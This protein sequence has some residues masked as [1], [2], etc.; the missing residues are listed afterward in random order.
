MIRFLIVTMALMLSCLGVEAQ[1]TPAQK[2]KRM[3]WWKDARFGMF[4]HWGTYSV[5]EG[6]WNGQDRYGEWIRDSARIP[7]DDYNKVKDKFNPVK[8]NAKDWA[9]MAK[10]A[11]MRYVV[12]TSKHHEGFA[13]FDSK[14]SD[15]DIMA[16]PFKRDILKE[17]SNAVRAEGLQMCWYHSIM[18]W[19]NPDY[20]PRRPWENRPVGDADMDRY[21]KFLRN[22]VTELL[23]NYGP[24][25]LMWF[26]GEWESTWNHAYGQALYNLCRKLQ[27]NVIVN[28][29]VDVGRGG[30]GGLSDAGFAGD[31]GTP[32]QEVPATGIPGVDWETCMTM[33][34]N[35]GYNRVDKNYKST[36]QLIQLL[37]D[38]VSKGGNYLLNIGP[39]PNGEFP[40][41]SVQR[42]KEIGDW[43]AVN[44]E[45]I[46][47]TSPSSFKS[48][49]WG[50]S[51]TKGNRIYL[52]IFDWPASGE[53][54]VPGL[55]NSVK[56]VKLLG[57]RQSLRAK[58][59]GPD[60]VLTLPKPVGKRVPVVRID[61]AGAPIIYDA[62]QLKYV[63]DKFVSVAK[64]SMDAKNLD[65][66]Y[67]LDGK[68]PTTK[69]PKYTGPVTVKSSCLVKARSF[70]KGKPV[71][72]VSMASFSKVDPWPMIQ[73]R[74]GVK[75]TPG[76]TAK[77]YDGAVDALPMFEALRPEST[78]NI[79]SIRLI[80]AKRENYSV[81][82]SG[83]LEVT[84]D[85]AYEF[86]L[87][88]D[89]GS[90]LWIDGQLVVDNDGLHSS[91]VK[92]GV[93]PLAK[94]LH[95]LRVEWFNKSGGADLALRLGV[96]GR[97]LQPVA[98]SALFRR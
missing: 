65:V 63:A 23:T 27:P 92:T 68:T 21:V 9:H 64:V 78:Q 6:A 55:G 30:M 46:Y 40:P 91:Q 42:L 51:T 89:D 79:E 38:I 7:I 74:P 43:M 31:Y 97:Q 57:S 75:L 59:A 1:E 37:C 12:I 35:W 41:E 29:R 67:T 95:H 90:R 88:S 72:A 16:T 49:P 17:L 24:I 87:Q 77:V 73:L 81:V 10:E 34:D 4:I 15:Y 54:V 13:M 22:Q 76:V 66:H 19:H 98:G 36:T 18:D 32:E 52:Q 8:F 83:Y 20:L 56:K 33:N 96:A 48:L 44:G 2:A 82:Y 93:A 60:W 94:G 26:D 14:Y 50:R 47:G 39:Q 3:Q 80:D 69:S 70:H 11:G 28:N 5:L 53:L 61:L 84:L 62:P 85:E 25:G 58:R 86:A 45:S 71:S